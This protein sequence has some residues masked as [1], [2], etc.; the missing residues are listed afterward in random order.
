VEGVANLR[1]SIIPIFNLR[2]LLGSDPK[3]SDGKTRTIVVNVGS[4]ILGCV[5]DSVSQV[6]RISGEAIQ[7]APETI[8]MGGASYV[9]GFARIGDQLLIVLNVDALLDPDRL[10]AL[11]SSAIPDAPMEG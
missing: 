1:G 4:R 5:V 7:P 6:M 2:L 3:P 8:K 10:D 9:D 11:S